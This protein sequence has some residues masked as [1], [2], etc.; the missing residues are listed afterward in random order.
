MADPRDTARDSR[1]KL[2]LEGIAAAL[3][4]LLTLGTLGVILWDEWRSSGRPAFV[5][6]DVRSVTEAEGGFVMELRAEN[7]GD[8]TAAEVLVRGELRRG[9]EVVE[10]SEATFD[11]VPRHSHRDGGLFF[12]HDPRNL[13]IEV[14]ALG[15][16]DP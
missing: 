9:D 13:E 16:V 7:R 5:A 1:G 14:R 15:Y 10:T 6:V 11:Y 2:W 8:R 12:T 3:G 4:A